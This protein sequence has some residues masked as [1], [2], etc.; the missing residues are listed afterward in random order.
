MAFHEIYSIAG[1]A[2]PGYFEYRCW[3]YI[4]KQCTG[5]SSHGPSGRV[6]SRQSVTTI[7]E[8]AGSET[9][10]LDVSRLEAVA[11]ELWRASLVPNSNK[12]YKSAQKMFK[13]FC[14]SYGRSQLPASKQLLILFVAD[15][16]DR[17]CYTTARTYLAAV[18]YMHIMHGYGDPLRNVCN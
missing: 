2:Y 17:V 18:H 10:E 15:L 11:K 8:S 12:T 9:A 7:M 1:S 3:C 6:D 5:S 16:A 13:T 4:S 14:L